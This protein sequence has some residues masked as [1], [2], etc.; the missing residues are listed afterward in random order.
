M[1]SSFL[2]KAI[3]AS[4]A[5]ASIVACQKD[6]PAT[7]GNQGGNEPGGGETTYTLI[8]NPTNVSFTANSTAPQEITV[9]TNAPQY[10]VGE[11]ASWYTATPNGNKV[12]ITPVEANTGERRSH[13]LVISAEGASPVNVTVSQD[14][15]TEIPASLSGSKY[16]V[17]QLDA[18]STEL[19]GDKIILSL[20]T[21]G[22][23]CRLDIW[24]DGTSMV[25]VESTGPNFYGNQGYVALEVGNIGWSGGGYVY[26]DEEN[27]GDPI[28][29]FDQIV[30]DNG[31]GWYFHAAVK[32]T[33][34]AGNNFALCDVSGTSY[35]IKWE[36]HCTL[37]ETDWQEI[38]IPMTEILATG[39][40]GPV[41]NTNNLTIGSSTKA[42][43]KFYYDA[44]FIYKK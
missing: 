31:E 19:L 15:A 27:A 7:E 41:K 20:A 13:T 10:S 22:T 14:E 2:F 1:K 44:L 34:G 38:E 26:V 40:T 23:T 21:N 17:W 35:T 30:A 9:T 33:P 16:I 3:C 8:V 39:W 25:G 24:P 6:E 18:N 36:D 29:G 42:G 28:E 5:V 11:T 4:F 12:T 37:S 43:D 32:G